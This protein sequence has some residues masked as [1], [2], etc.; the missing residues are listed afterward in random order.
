MAT[1]TKRFLGIAVGVPACLLIL[2]AAAFWA[3]GGF[4]SS[5]RL[6]EEDVAGT[7][8]STAGATLEVMPGGRARLAG[9]SGWD[10]VGPSA[11]T[12]DRFSAKGTWVFA[13]H[14]DE[15]PG[16]R[17]QFVVDGAGGERCADWFAIRSQERAG[18]LGYHGGD[19]E[20]Y[21]RTGTAA[22]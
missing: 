15:D 13:T 18:F 7:W 19:R 4:D 16:V 9:A 1:D 12:A 17:V 8:H 5:S 2:S 3:L 20:T 11:P 21:R 14:S 6:T 22:R 10:C